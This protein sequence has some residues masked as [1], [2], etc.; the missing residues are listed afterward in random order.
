MVYSM[1]LQLYLLPKEQTHTHL[2]A[3]VGGR[4]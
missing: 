3:R 1:S 2:N 4:I